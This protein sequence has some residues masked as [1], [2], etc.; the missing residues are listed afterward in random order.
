MGGRPVAVGIED[1]HATRQVKAAPGEVQAAIRRHAAVL[2]KDPFRGTF[3]AL[4][5][6][7]QKTLKRWRARV[8]EVPNLYKLDLPGGWRALYFVA[9]DARRRAVFV[10]EV[11]RHTEYDR[12]LGYD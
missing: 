10:I 2:Q 12:L 7:P 4:R 3:I 8:G 9:S 5:R 1:P 6:V 11:V